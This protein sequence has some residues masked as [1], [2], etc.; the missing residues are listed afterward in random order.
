MWLFPS[1]R[2]VVSSAIALGCLGLAA[3]PVTAQSFSSPTTL[4]TRL[5][6][7][8]PLQAYRDTSGRFEI[9]LPADY[10]VTNT[11]TGLLFASPDGGFGGMVDT[12]SAQG[13][14]FSLEDLET[15]L[16][17]EFEQRLSH[18]TWQGSYAHNQGGVRIDWVGED[19]AGN[20]L[21]A[22][23][24]IQQQ[25][26]T[27]F[28]LTMWGINTAYSTYNDDADAIFATYRIQP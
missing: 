12:G 23:S 24:F 16:K 25:G 19:P 4:A 9:A 3:C 26:D 20:Q 17:T 6:T 27:I 15:A 5:P 7:V 21:D 22:I 10:A 11:P 13:Q 28:V 14:W 8:S 1:P 18:I 2:S